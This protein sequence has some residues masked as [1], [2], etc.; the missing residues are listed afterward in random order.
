MSQSLLLLFMRGF[1]SAG[2][3]K[4]PLVINLISTAILFLSTFG[5]VKFFYFSESFR[6]FI[7]V[8]LKVED[9]SGTAVLMLPLGFSLA[10]IINSLL[11]WVAFER[12]FRGFS[13]G[14]IKALFH[15]LGTSVI[16]GAVTYLG[17]NIFAPVF[18]ITSLIGIFLQ[19]A[20]AGLLGIV[21]GIIVLILLKSRELSEIWVAIHKKF[22]KTK[23]IVTDS[24][25]V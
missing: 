13:V 3:T 18:D 21:A 14:V 23:I 9:L 10:V 15:Y 12:Q 6:H 11:H 24:E 2:F 25:I 16:I 8:I 5:L 17:L 7:G 20:L 22:W 19:G 1:Y 4:K